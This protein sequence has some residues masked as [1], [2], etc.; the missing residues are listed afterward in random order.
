MVAGWRR[1]KADIAAMI[2]RNWD[3]DQCPAAKIP[4]RRGLRIK[5]QEP[6]S[7]GKAI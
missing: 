4:M 1:R 3:E 7:D 2:R 5:T 6:C